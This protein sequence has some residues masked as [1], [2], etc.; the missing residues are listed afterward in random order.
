MPLDSLIVG[1]IILLICGAACFYLYMRIS[2]IE[3]KGAMMES[4]IVD[5]KMAIDSLMTS[6]YDGG[7]SP[8]P[9]SP[10]PNVSISAPVALDSSESEPIPEESF[11]SSVLEQAH[12]EA[13]EA[14]PEDG[15]TLEKAMES[16]EN[17][18]VV[19]PDLDAL[20]KQ[21]LFTLAEK[22]GLRAKKSSTRE[23]LLS[24]LRR[25]SPVQNVEV[26]TGA[27][28]V[29]GSLSQDVASLDGSVNVDLGLGASLE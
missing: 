14:R 4:V 8:V 20:T 26:T 9:I 25:A 28:N 29:A 18:A 15:M 7:G 3:R 1:L 17:N 16:F 6:G 24:V 5:L 10:Q 23:Q 19:E 13:Q 2:F 11:Y 12:D 21:E 22:R 27:E